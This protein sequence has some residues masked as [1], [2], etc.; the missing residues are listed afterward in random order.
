MKKLLLV[1]ALVATA[2]STLL[3]QSRVVTGKVTAS[4]DGAALPGVSVSLK[5]TSRGVTTAA[6]GSYKISVDNGAAL[7]FSFVGYKAQTINVGSQSTINVVLAADAAELSEVVV[8]ALGLTRTK[9][10][11]PYAAQQV[12]GDELTRVRSGNAF[13]AL[14]GKVAGLQIIQGNAIGGSTNV[15]IRGNKSLTGNNQALFV[16]DG[17]PVDNSVK[18]TSNQQTGRGG[19]DYG[20]AAADINPDDIESMTVLKGAAATALYGSRAS[21]GVIMITTK[22]AKKGLGLT[23]NA[24]LTV[25]TIDKS[26][27][28]TYQNQYGAGYS[29][30]YQKDGFLYFDANG[31]GTKDLV[32]NT[33]EDASYGTKFNPSLMVYHWDSFDPAGPNYLKAKP[34]VAAANTPVKFY[35][36]A[37]SNNINVQLDGATDQGTFKLGFTRND[38]RG[39]LP[40]SSVI[41]N[42]MNLAGSYN[43]S[44]K[45]T[46][47]AAAN[48]SV[49]DGKG[50]YG[51]G[52]SGLN[53]NQNFRQWYQ[54]NVDILEQ[55]EAYFRNQQN[56]TWNWSDPSSAAGLK[57]IYTDNY[58]WTRYQ[59][60]QNDTRSRIFGNAMLNYKAADFLNFM[61]RVT[62]DTYNEFQEERIAVGSQGVPAYSRFDRTF[63]E[64]NYDLMGNFDKE[65]LSGLNMKA[66]AGLNLRKSYVRSISAAT[67]GGLIVPGL[68]SIANSRG[69][70]SAPSENYNPREVFGVFGG[71]TFTYKDFL[72][73]DGTIRQDKSSTL[74]VANNAYLYYA[75]SASWLFSHHIEDLPWLTSGKLRLNYATVG[76]DAP[77]G[78]I[79]NVYDKPDP[80]GSTILFSA[81]STQNNPFLKPEQTQSKE[82]GLEMAFL[83]NRLGFDFTYYHTNT[84]DQILPA[85]VSSATG[86][87]STFVNAGNIENKGFEVSLYATPI[88]TPDFS[89]NVNVNWTKNNSL[90]LSLYNDSKN[91]QLAT[92]Q[93][94]VSL[95]ATVGQPYGI[96]QG[97]TWKT[98]NGQKLVKANGRYDITST[99]TNN[100]GNVN[101]DWIGGINN[102]FKYKNVTL[103]F[104]ID[105]KRGGSVFSL[106]QYYGQA[107][108]VYPESVV[109]ND[110]GNPSRSPIAEGGGVIMP[111]VLADGSVNTIRVEN[112][113]GT[114]GYAQN[115]A[116][117]FVYDA[118][119]IKLREANIVYSLPSSVVRKL[120]GVKGVD[121]SIFGRNLWIIQKYVPYADPE[122][123]LSAG[124][125]QGNQ[126]GAYPTTRSI[127]FNIKLLF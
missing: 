11:L 123:N 67:N 8:T 26:T 76:N 20:N 35:E 73:L 36:T 115:P 28:A 93:G 24:G 69:T 46:A 42:I 54:T 125:I 96:L 108:G 79:K 40:N 48:F 9:N 5:G 57:P 85:S 98:L 47:S 74:P 2:F 77:W 106:D 62:I 19:Y 104:L 109:L 71:L 113:Y 13:S 91:L 103:N 43:I 114:F 99:T 97:K 81:P 64:L 95:N 60:Y 117:A 32:I 31:D 15:V 82:I 110:K 41:K 119:Y 86:F 59:N 87:S 37:I 84:L 56:V 16:V 112:D 10:S 78:S 53:V 89:W 101:P 88:K 127:G 21:N 83:Q 38:E 39:T 126:S 118:S 92:F 45:V 30:P 27:F 102:S 3:A 25:G 12:K 58:Y 65:I 22:K 116:A 50:R 4:E 55:K 23:V 90:V 72:T 107:T 44:K 7:Q 120:G 68:Y 51:S 94:G 66:L 33:A 1:M 75:G 17:V 105:M 63:Q 121:L 124:N 80:F 52:Y 34:Y 111:G 29:D 61:G 70:V 14:S 18:N 100:I 49:I 6:D 122:E